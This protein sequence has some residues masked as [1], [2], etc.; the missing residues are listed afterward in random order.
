[1]NTFLTLLKREYWEHKTGF[2]W[3]PVGI[4]ALVLFTSLLLVIFFTND[5]VKV[6]I[7]ATNPTDLL[8]LWEATAS[9]GD[10]NLAMTAWY[11]M[12][13]FNLAIVMAFVGYFYCL[14]ALYDDR[15][16]KSIL[17]WKSLPISDTQ[18]VLS[19]VVSVT[20]VLPLVIWVISMVTNLG[21]MLIGLLF[22]AMSNGDIA[23]LVFS[24]SAIFMASSYQL[25]ANVMA[26]LWISPFIGYLLFI[27]SATKRVPFLVSWL[28][29]IVVL[30]VE[31]IAFRSAH[32]LGWIGNQFTGIG[33]AYST[34]MAMMSQVEEGGVS[35]LVEVLGRVG[36]EFDSGWGSYPNQLMDPNLWFGLIVGAVFIVGAIY[37][38]R[39]RDEAL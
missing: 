1:M 26:V 14:G 25:M 8:G 5:T 37:I 16:D 27:S 38:R 4:S 39:Y 21:M 6:S 32:F 30:I 24:P 36:W 35:E 19:K 7:G 28:P 20:V 23:G 33:K 34:P 11:Y 13:I 22:A 18:T 12:N 15:K 17:F 29:I 31:S 10:K 2:Q 3:V 9:E